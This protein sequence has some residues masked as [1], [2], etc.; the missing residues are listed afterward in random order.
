MLQEITMTT[1]INHALMSPY[2][3]SESREK[4]VSQI[5]EILSTGQLMFGRHNERLEKN[6]AEF[7]G[8]S[9]AVSLNSCTTAL[10]ISLM[11]FGVAGGE[12]LVPSGSFVTDISSILFS[13]ATPVMV[14]MDP[15]TLSF[16][17]EDLE[18]KITPD[19]RAIVWVHLTGIISPDYLQLLEL[20]KR[21]NLVV[22]EDAAHAHGSSIDG[23]TAGSIG[24]VGCFSF[25][26]T[27]IMTSGTGGMLTTDDEALATFAREMRLFGKDL[28]TGEIKHL[29]NDW[30]LDEIRACIASNQ[31]TELPKM[32]SRRRQAAAAYRTNLAN[33]PGIRLI[34][35]PKGNLPAYY[36]FPLFLDDNLKAPEIGA[37][38]KTEYGIEAKQIYRATHEEPV[39]RQ[40]DRGDLK[41]TTRILNSSL[42]LPM[43][44]GIT[45]EDAESIAN[46]L[47]KVVRDVI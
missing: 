1:N 40:Y 39:F 17:L 38:M 36:Q 44:P 23:R 6:F 20:A 24:K 11:H 21:H 28:K 34:G 45:A 22:I 33:Q 8:V 15:E 18:R 42:C 3:S 12:V 30:F 25:Y 29:G 47:I 2:F 13:G 4:I 7:T 14:D 26:P 46:A 32:I 37:R 5:D 16:D 10:T 41:Q 19:S 35:L 43:H 31:L 9:H 27:K